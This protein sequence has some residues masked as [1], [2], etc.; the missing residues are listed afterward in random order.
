M[1]LESATR[2]IRSRSQ[3]RPTVR[4]VPYDAVDAAG[5]DQV[6][7][8][9]DASLAA[10]MRRLRRRSQRM[11]SWLAIAVLAGSIAALGVISF[12]TH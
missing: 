4:A 12:L 5:W 6:V 9:V 11:S 1:T 7:S 2:K 3:G 10:H 8:P